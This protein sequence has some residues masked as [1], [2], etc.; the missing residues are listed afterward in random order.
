MNGVEEIASNRFLYSEIFTGYFG[1]ILE[2]IIKSINNKD[3]I[4][5][6]ETKI[7]EYLQI[8]YRT[9][10]PTYTM[11]LLNQDLD[12]ANIAFAEPITNDQLFKFSNLIASQLLTVFL[13]YK[14]GYLPSMSQSPFYFVKNTLLSILPFHPDESK[15]KINQKIRSVLNTIPAEL[16][17][18]INQKPFSDISILYWENFD[19]SSEQV[20]YSINNSIN[21]VKHHC[22]KDQKLCCDLITVPQIAMN[23]ND[24]FKRLDDQ[25]QSSFE[26]PDILFLD[27][28][29]IAEYKSKG[30]IFSIASVEKNENIENHFIEKDKVLD[31]GKTLNGSLDAFPI[32]RNFHV[33]AKAKVNNISKIKDLKYQKI[34][35]D[36]NTF[37][38]NWIKTF[39]SRFNAEDK[40]WFDSFYTKALKD[41]ECHDN[42]CKKDFITNIPNIK[43]IPLQFAKGAHASYSFFAYLANCQSNQRSFIEVKEKN[44]DSSRFIYSISIISQDNFEKRLKFFFDVVFSY[45]PVLALTLDHKYS[46]FI[47]DCYEDEWFDFCLPLESALFQKTEIDFSSKPVLT[48]TSKPLSCLGGFTLA[49]SD[50]CKDPYKAV[51]IIKKIS[52]HRTPGDSMLNPEGNVVKIN[53]K[54][55]IIKYSMEK[56]FQSTILTQNDV[57]SEIFTSDTLE[58]IKIPEDIGKRPCYK[59]WRELE[60]IISDVIRL[61]VFALFVFRHVIYIYNNN[62]ELHRLQKGDVKLDNINIKNILENFIH[63][64][65]HEILEKD[66]LSHFLFEEH[67]KIIEKGKEAIKDWVRN[68]FDFSPSEQKYVKEIVNELLINLKGK[69]KIQTCIS[70]LSKET[71]SNLYSKIASYCYFNGYEFKKI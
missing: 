54:N 6:I 67:S 63:V 69:I 70:Y 37:I 23:Y 56:A 50:S 61:N 55:E 12:N 24:Y 66:I 29:L 58:Y 32:S 59:G 2:A 52:E 14:K 44:K 68:S 1:N 15:D 4:N 48:E 36:L 38:S 21:I 41:N 64:I 49:I 45:V 13:L 28:I 60:S 51:E 40:E 42:V 62:N 71:S 18:Y 16:W 20:R 26:K 43:F 39:D 35:N 11:D 3:R 25:L 57:N 34:K 46:G 10:D 17:H 9:M 65:G 8:I 27:S 33:P 31:I 53:Y 30:V 19:R 7:K 47:R 22:D 5:N